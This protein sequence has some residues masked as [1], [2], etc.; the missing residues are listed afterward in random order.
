[1]EEPEA[2]QFF[3]NLIPFWIIILVISAGVI[4]LT[5][6][7]RQG[8][9]KQRLEKEVL[10][11]RYQQE[12]LRTSIDIQ[13]KERKRIAHDLHDELGARLSMALMRLKQHPDP[14]PIT[15]EQ[16]AEI[17]EQLEDQLELALQATKRISY[18]LM[19]PQ[20][21]NLG[22]YQAL[23]VRAED[24]RKAGNLMVNMKKTG[25]PDTMPWPMQLAM[26][27]ILSELLN[28]TLKHAEATE[29]SIELVVDKGHLLCLYCDNGKG[30]SDE[31]KGAGL[32]LQSLEGRASALNGTLE[33]GNAHDGGFWAEI[34][35]PT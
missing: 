35:L 25:D 4:L 9:S 29:V 2:H 24:A 7:F 6:K 17:L 18:E 28:N 13:E 16:T 19:P 15:P 20:L 8:L 26:Y 30:M 1:M 12:L 33:Y 11:N 31:I 21:V 32:G 10:K 22:L 23:K 14:T 27:R 34:S 3:I 5:R